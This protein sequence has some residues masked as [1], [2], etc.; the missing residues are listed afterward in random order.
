MR[1]VRSE[2][3]R[4]S[5]DGDAVSVGAGTGSS[6]RSSLN[7]TIVRSSS[8]L[9]P[10]TSPLQYWLW[11]LI[12]LAGAAIFLA[13]PGAWG[14]K[15]QSVLHGL[16]AQTPTHTFTFAG[17]ALP[18]DGRMTGIYGGTIITF[19]WLALSRR[20]RYYGNPPKRVIAFLAGCVVAM[21]VDGLNSLLKD[22]GLWHPYPPEN[23]LRLVTGFGTGVA[24][25]VILTWL[26][27]SSMWNF[28]RNK[29][30]VRSFGDLRG[31]A[32][33]GMIFGTLV[34]SGWGPLFVP[35]SALL[36]ASAWLTLT[37]LML[38]VVLLGLKIDERVSRMEDL[39][40][41]GAVAAILGLLA[42]LA[43]AGGRFWLE[44]VV[45]IPLTPV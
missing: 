9:T 3:G 11:T 39:H 27:A 42:M 6:A 35:L 7:T 23:V 2:D 31:V 17:N 4:R 29:P 13:F 20:L 45:G 14:T 43:L 26:L 12:V 22:L 32:F 16:C 44:R 19:A 34:L 40:V 28:A 21:G 5:E 37:V 15:A 18:F 30:V 41:P 10:L 24:L 38:V 36:M 25:A 8:L 1:E 33:G